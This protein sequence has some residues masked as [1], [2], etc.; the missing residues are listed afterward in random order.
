MGF[1]QGGSPAKNGSRVYGFRM[2]LGFRMGL[3]FMGLGL[4][5]FRV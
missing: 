1:W 3:G 2:S 5:P 4:G